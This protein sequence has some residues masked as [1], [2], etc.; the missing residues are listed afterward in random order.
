MLI[1]TSG[2][3]PGNKLKQANREKKQGGG[4]N[5]RISKAKVGND[6]ERRPVKRA[7]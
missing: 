2:R 3:L 4:S 1:I 7:K 6:K 5:T